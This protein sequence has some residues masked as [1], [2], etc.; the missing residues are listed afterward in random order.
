MV[1]RALRQPQP[2]II[3]TLLLERGVGIAYRAIE[4]PE[5]WSCPSTL[6]RDTDGY[7]KVGCFYESS[8]RIILK[9]GHFRYQ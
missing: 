7:A 3:T 6:L 9:A 2:S 5:G 1:S 8:N 4:A